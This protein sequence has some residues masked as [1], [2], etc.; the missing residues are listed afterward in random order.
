MKDLINETDW[1]IHSKEI[2]EIIA[3]KT[4]NNS[5]NLRD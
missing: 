5:S 1:R 3:N 2:K 4:L